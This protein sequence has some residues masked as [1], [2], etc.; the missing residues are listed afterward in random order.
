MLLSS[1]HSSRT[2]ASLSLFTLAAVAAATL[3][4]A[5]LAALGSIAPG[6]GRV[7][8]AVILLVGAVASGLWYVRPSLHWLRYPQ[9]QL[10]RDLVA[11]PLNGALLFGAVLGVGWLTVVVTPFVWVG[12][13]AAFASGS[14]LWGAVYGVGFGLGRSAQLVVHYLRPVPEDPTEVVLRTVAYQAT[15]MRALGLV[16]AMVI[17]AAVVF[18]SLS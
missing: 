15:L 10:R 14:M 16:G 7:A 17:I 13:A 9:K 8:L 11:T 4:Y 1:G 5:L 2:R 18:T 3:A 6:T 12:A